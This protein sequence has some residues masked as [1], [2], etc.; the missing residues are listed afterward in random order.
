MHWIKK[1]QK[2]STCIAKAKTLP[3]REASGTQAQS[4]TRQNPSSPAALMP[5]LLFKKGT[6]N[7]ITTRYQ[8]EPFL[9]SAYLN[10]IEILLLLQVAPSE[11]S[12]LALPH[13]RLRERRPQW[14][15]MRPSRPLLEASSTQSWAWPRFRGCCCYCCCVLLLVYQ[16]LVL[17]LIVY[18]VVLTFLLLHIKKS[19]NFNHYDVSDSLRDQDKSILNTSKRLSFRLKALI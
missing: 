9:R 13:M 4:K 1:G 14:C 11:K 5:P 18:D 8:A 6:S 12:V 7:L 16:L 2:W 15:G 3:H 10:D 19:P 17:L